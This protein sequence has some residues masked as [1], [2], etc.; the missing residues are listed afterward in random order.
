M[1]VATVMCPSL[2]NFVPRD[3]SW[4]RSPLLGSAIAS[5]EILGELVL[6]SDTEVTNLRRGI[7][8]YDSAFS[9]LSDVEPPHE[10]E[11]VIRALSC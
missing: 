10:R 7:L 6:C 1:P 5:L 8:N 4:Q 11:L 9:V 3:N 2:H